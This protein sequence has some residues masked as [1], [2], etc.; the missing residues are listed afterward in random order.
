[1]KCD[2]WDKTNELEVDGCLGFREP[3]TSYCYE[4]SR[5]YDV[6]WAGTYADQNT[7]IGTQGGSI[8]SESKT[9]IHLYGNVWKAFRL[10]KPY[11]V[12]GNTHVSFKFKLTKEA[13][14]HAICFDDDME[15]DTFGGFQKRCV[16]VA[17]TELGRWN[18][19]HIFKTE[20]I[21]TA[22]VD[23]EAIEV[24]RQVK[25]GHFFNKRG[26]SINFV[27]FVQDNDADPYSGISSFWDITFY[28]ELPVS[29]FQYLDLYS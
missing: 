8:V 29:S 1:M 24:T 26:T 25:I 28:E 11:P 4:E 14:G 9:M 10:T 6:S 12:T 15:P 3:G 27:G 21:D 5:T 22:N 17:G 7:D 23:N 20:K 2:K 19:N 18:N 16:A 13:E